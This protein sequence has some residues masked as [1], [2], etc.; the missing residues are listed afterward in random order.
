M[1]TMVTTKAQTQDG[2]AVAERLDAI[3]D[4]LQ[5]VL[6]LSSGR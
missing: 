3:Y 2:A 1:P 6:K 5:A 4:V